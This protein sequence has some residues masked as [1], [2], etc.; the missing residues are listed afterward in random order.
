V[1]QV[2]LPRYMIRQKCLWG[3]WRQATKPVL[4]VPVSKPQANIIDT[5]KACGLVLPGFMHWEYRFWAATLSEDKLSTIGECRACGAV[6]SSEKGRRLHGA[7]MGCSGKLTDAY[8]LLLKDS[9]CVIC[10]MRSYKTKWGVPICSEA[11]NTAW[12]GV[13]SQPQALTLALALIAKDSK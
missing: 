6:L 8:K 1:C 13:E 4:L 5:V 7:D 10:N 9:I 11:C 2:V 3:G 12:C